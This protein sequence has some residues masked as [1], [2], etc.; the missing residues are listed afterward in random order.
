MIAERT[1]KRYR[2]SNAAALREIV[3]ALIHFLLGIIWR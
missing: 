1:L 2:K 3:E